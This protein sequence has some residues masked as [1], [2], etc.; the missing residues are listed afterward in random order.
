VDGS[1]PR[2]ARL[3]RTLAAIGVGSGS[4]KC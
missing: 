2:L 3:A 1:V 4:A